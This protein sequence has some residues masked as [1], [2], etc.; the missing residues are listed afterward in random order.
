MSNHLNHH[1]SGL[2]SPFPSLVLFRAWCADL[3]S[4]LV[5]ILRPASL[6][7][8]GH[9]GC[10][11]TQ[12]A[13]LQVPVSMPKSAL[14]AYWERERGGGGRMP[15]EVLILIALLDGKDDW[16]GLSTIYEKLSQMNGGWWSL[17]SGTTQRWDQQSQ[18]EEIWRSRDGWDWNTKLTGKFKKSSAAVGLGTQ[19]VLP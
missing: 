15:S 4:C 3:I 10:L 16:K 13:A 14:P 19:A 18:K 9:W 12:R 2:H 6:H 8:A 1:C 11:H 17:S 5:W 7:L